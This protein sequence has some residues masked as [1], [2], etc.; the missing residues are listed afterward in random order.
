MSSIRGAGLRGEDA[1]AIYFESKGYI[2]CRN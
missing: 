2:V 1:V